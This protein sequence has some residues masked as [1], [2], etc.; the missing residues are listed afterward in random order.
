MALA[1]PIAEAPE[2]AHAP[3]ASGHAGEGNA[4]DT[5]VLCPQTQY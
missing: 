2:I 4:D 5:L 1:G 3:K